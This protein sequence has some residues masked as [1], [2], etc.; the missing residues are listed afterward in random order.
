[1]THWLLNYKF[2][3]YGTE[4]TAYLT[5]YGEYQLKGLNL[6]DPMCELFPTEVTIFWAAV[7]TLFYILLNPPFYISALKESTLCMTCEQGVHF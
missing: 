4:V 1:M 2:W 6:H 5:M 7:V 3:N